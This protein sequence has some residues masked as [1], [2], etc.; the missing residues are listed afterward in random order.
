MSTYPGDDPQPPAEPSGPGDAVPP[1]SETS[2]HTGWPDDTEPTQPV[3]PQQSGPVFNPTT[4]QPLGDPAA[5]SGPQDAP[6]G[7]A[8]PYGQAYGQPP[9]GEAP[10][11]GQA[12]PYGQAPSHSYGQAPYGQAP[13]PQAPYA[14]A[15]PFAP[16]RPDHPRATLALVLGIVGLVGGMVLCGVGLVA[17]PFAWGIGRSALKEIEAAQ[18]QLGGESSARAG[19][20]MGIIGTAL[21]ALA[22]LVL[23]G[24]GVLV[25]ASS[26]S[27]SSNV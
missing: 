8:P 25:L 6:G 24:F 16:A 21:L 17:S 26:S 9:Y 2:P 11:Y 12:P 19:M 7:Q 20:I 23:I 3:T 10:S 15:G 27:S 4:A 13:Y 1:E 14:A 22:V 18:G 5:G